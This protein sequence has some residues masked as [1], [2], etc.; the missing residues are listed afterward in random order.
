MVSR[1]TMVEQQVVVSS[2]SKQ[3]VTP[4]YQER[5]VLFVEDIID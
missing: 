3:D 4:R 1:T 2:I 5:H